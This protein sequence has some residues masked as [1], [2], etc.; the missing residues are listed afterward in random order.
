M[1][2]LM[3]CFSILLLF[4]SSSAEAAKHHSRPGVQRYFAAANP[5]GKFAFLL[6]MPKGADLDEVLSGSV[7]AESLIAW[8][9]K[10]GLCLDDS[11]TLALPPC[12]ENNPS[13]KSALSNPELYSAI[14]DAWSMRDS[15][16][17]DHFHAAFGK[18]EKAEQGMTGAMLAK[19]L[20]RAA[21]EHLLYMEIA[22]TPDD[23][24]AF[25]LGK[26]LG[27]DGNFHNTLENLE[28]N[29]LAR[30]VK[31]SL[32]EIRL[33]ESEKDGLLKCSTPDADPGC[34][35]S[36]HYLYAVSRN[37]TPGAVF[38]QL[39]TGFELASIDDSG[40]SGVLLK[41]PEDESM[42]DFS[43]HMQMLD[44]LKSI[45][46]GAHVAVNAG[47]LS[48]RLVPPE[49]LSSHVS[50]AVMLGHA[51]RIGQGADIMY[52]VKGLMQQ[53]SKRKVLVD[54]CPGRIGIVL[55]KNE[56]PLPLYLK[57]DVPASISSCDAGVLRSEISR[58][59]LEAALE[60]NLG[61]ADLKNIARNGL[62]HAFV[63]GKSLWQNASRFTPARP[64]SR[65]L[66]RLKAS[67]RCRNYLDANEKARLQWQ[68]ET[69]FRAFEK[70]Y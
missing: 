18:F 26:R 25:E 16:E 40:F 59:Y 15:K 24:A 31:S 50:E 68:L 10:K 33:S 53:L 42:Q 66:S 39:A 32:K 9:A 2:T 20:S 37:T 56:N 54:I 14:L 5:E 48:L 38:A 63:S 35:V 46:P 70:R 69:E 7:Y 28:N 65:D 47:E 52:E 22:L 23:G 51:E 61:Y 67:R 60:N 36:V 55:G 49:G 34:F 58:E 43:L 45:H 30:V 6:D 44:F 64:C 8:A 57:H 27:W 12:G 17:R 41:G 1:K 62:E 11:L 19:M 3:L 29:G 21:R 4:F 13:V